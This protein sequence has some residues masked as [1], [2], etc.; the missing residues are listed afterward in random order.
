MTEPGARGGAFEEAEGAADVRATTSDSGGV[1]GR[2]RKA[3]GE[4]TGCGALLDDGVR[5]QAASATM[6]DTETGRARARLTNGRL[7]RFGGVTG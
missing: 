2:A 7:P 1:W 5:P 4:G 3:H 6:S